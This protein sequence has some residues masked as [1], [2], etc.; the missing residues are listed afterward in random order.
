[1]IE[2][3]NISSRHIWVIKPALSHTLHIPDHPKPT[4][5]DVRRRDVLKAEPQNVRWVLRGGGGDSTRK[6]GQITN[7]TPGL[8]GLR[9]GW[10]QI[11]ERGNRKN[12]A[13]LYRVT[14]DVVQNLP[15][16]SNQK[17][18][19]G[20]VCFLSQWEALDNAMCHPVL[21]IRS[22]VQIT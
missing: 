3:E 4:A 22:R 11:S 16:T 5:H 13:Q 19:F 17:F 9:I 18:R 10:G 6:S 15:L 20:Q 12:L 21:L 8:S 14:H 1:M 7:I 2:F